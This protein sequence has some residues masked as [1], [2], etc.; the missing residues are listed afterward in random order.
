MSRPLTD[1]RIH[2][3][4]HAVGSIVRKHM[5]ERLRV[6]NMISAVLSDDKSAC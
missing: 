5:A 4:Q 3:I 6:S 2:T 1:M